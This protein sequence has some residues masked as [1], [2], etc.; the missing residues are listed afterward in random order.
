MHWPEDEMSTRVTSVVTSLTGSG[1]WRV[2]GI[3]LPHGRTVG[4]V[5]AKDDIA[6]GNVYGAIIVGPVLTT[7]THVPPMFTVS[8]V[9]L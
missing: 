7:A 5:A 2:G 1:A 3:A 6:P 9:H 8:A 4:Q